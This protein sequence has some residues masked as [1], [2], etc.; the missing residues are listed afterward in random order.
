MAEKEVEGHRQRKHRGG[1]GEE[2]KS[3]LSEL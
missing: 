2:D 1:A 3:E